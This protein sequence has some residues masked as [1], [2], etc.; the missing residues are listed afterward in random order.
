MNLVFFS[1]DHKN[2]NSYLFFLFL[3]LDVDG[4][5]HIL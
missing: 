1:V 4:D 5:Q 3:I 2:Q